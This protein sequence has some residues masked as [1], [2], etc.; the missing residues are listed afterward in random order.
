MAGNVAL[1][2]CPYRR[3]ITGINH[4]WYPNATSADT[5]ARVEQ[6]F[7]GAFSADRNA[8]REIPN[9]STAEPALEPFEEIN[10]SPL[11][12]VPPHEFL[13][14]SFG[15]AT[16]VRKKGATKRRAPCEPHTSG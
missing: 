7:S 13:R 5:L 8:G 3:P 11:S 15:P 2:D 10:F 4:R 16:F 1:L 6:R 12:A 14:R 9:E